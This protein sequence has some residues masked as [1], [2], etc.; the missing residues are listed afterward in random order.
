MVKCFAHLKMCLMNKGQQALYCFL[1]SALGRAESVA[2]TG[3]AQFQAVA[4]HHHACFPKVLLTLFILPLSTWSV[5]FHP[6]C[7]LPLLW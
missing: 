5:W 6:M 1:A 7:T 4:I 2:V 3:C